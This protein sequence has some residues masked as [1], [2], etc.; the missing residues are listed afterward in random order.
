MAW[1]ACGARLL[2]LGA[3]ALGTACVGA[4]PKPPEPG[5]GPAPVPATAPSPGPTAD[6]L[7][8]F[9]MTFGP[10]QAVWEHFGHTALWVHD[11]A[12]HSEQAYNY[13]MFTF[14][15]ANFWRRFIEGKMLY[16]VEGFDASLFANLYVREDRSVWVQELALTPA[17]REALREFLVWN[18]QPDNRYY[19]YDYYRDGCATRVRDALDRVLGGQI[20]AQTSRLPSGS[21]YRSHSLEL[22]EDA[23]P[24]Y[25]GLLLGLAQP[26]D[27]PISLW[28][29]LFL[30]LKLQE[31]LRRV[32]VRAADGHTVPLV[33]SERALY[34]STRPIE[35][36]D[37]PER[38]WKYLLI[39]VML[40]LALVAL[41]EGAR[42]GYPVGRARRWA[43]AG[44][45]LVGGAWT[46]GSG[47]FGLLLVFLW[48]LTAHVT[49]QN[50]ENV[51]QFD[52]LALALAVLLPAALYGAGR[53][54]RPARWLAAVIAGLSVVGLLLKATPWFFQVNAGIL[55]L[56]LPANLALAWALWR[57][58]GA[59]S[60]AAGK[61]QPGGAGTP[62]SAR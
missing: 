36:S 54:A 28:E 12:H 21:T 38:T 51:L 41:A 52:P 10:G 35:P 37:P 3:V 29:E 56:A 14:R 2:V 39:G 32:T 31:T 18:E 48:A 8:I 7:R 49:S 53:T 26:T 6:S 44:L 15:Q 33:A 60:A 24:A 58:T 59:R 5:L 43:R 62:T 57:G 11:P 9:L 13:G 46:L 30:P 42:S 22:V 40:G 1:R 27:R 17:Q 34:T 50:N 61:P 19:P 16:W 23:P 25:T 4:K 20:Y 55:A 45:A 47:L